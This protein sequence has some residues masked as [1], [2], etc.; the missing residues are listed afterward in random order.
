MRK[1]ITIILL[2]FVST[3]SLFA[4]STDAEITGLVSDKN[5][6]PLIGVSVVVKDRS[7]MGTVTDENGKF[8]IK[9]NA[10]NILIFNYVGFE[11][12]EIPV[13]EKTVINVTLNENSKSVLSEI[14][15]TGAGVQRKATVTGAITTVN[16]KS[17]NIPTA[18]ITNALAGNVA[19]IIAMQTSGEPGSNNS[20]F[21]IRGISTFGANQSALILVDGVERPFNEVNIEDIESFSVLK[22]ASATAI[23]GSKGANGV[24]I[25]TTKKGEAGKVN[26][27]GKAEYGYKTF[28]RLPEFVD[29]TTYATLANEAKITRNQ[30]PLYTPIE[31]DIFKNGLDSDLYPNISWQDVMLK[32]GSSSNRA[33]INMSGGGSTA[34]YFVSGSYQN[35]DGMYKSDQ[36]MKDYKTNSS[37]SRWNYRANVDMD[38]TKTTLVSI[39]VSGF[40]ESQNFPGLRNDIWYS[41]VGQTPVSIPFLYSNGKV[42]AY[43]TGNKTNPWVLATQTGYREYWK[44]VAQTNINLD[45]NLK[46]ITDGLKFRAMVAYDTR[47]ENNIDRKKWPEQYNIERRRD[48]DGN[49]VMKRVSTESIMYQESSASGYR[50][51]N[52]EAILTYDKLINQKHRMGALLKAFQNEN[53]TTSLNTGDIISGIA[54]RNLGTA[55]RVTYGY[56]DRYLAEFNFGYTGSENFKSGKQFGF[57]P[58]VSFGWNIAQEKFVSDAAPWLSQFKIRYSYGEVGNDKVGY[59]NVI[60]R[61]PYLSTISGSGIGGWNFGDI[62]NGN[63]Y[64][65]LHFEQVASDNLSWEVA[66][67]HNL[68]L[69]VSILNGLFSGSLDV[70]Q[71]TRDNIY[72][73]R[74]YLPVMV[75]LTSTPFANVGKMQSRGFDSQFNFHKKIEAFD[76]TLRGNITYAKNQ[77][78]EYD[79]EELSLPYMMTKGYRYNQAKGLVSE[80]L[81]KDYEEIR[82]SPKQTY[83]EYLPGDIKYKDV[84]GDGIINDDDRV[85]IGST[86]VPNLVYGLGMSLRWTNFDFNIH[87]QGSGKS[88]YFLNG[89]G[90]YPFSEGDWGNIL[91]AVSNPSNRWIS[92]TISGDPATENTSAMF[93]RLSYSS[94]KSPIDLE[95]TSGL[96]NNYRESTFWLRDGSYLRLKTLEMGYSVPQKISSKFNMN[97]VRFYLIGNNLFLW[98]KLKIWDPELGSG[99]GMKYPPMKMVTIGLTFNI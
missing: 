40:L 5:N 30:E 29:G 23:Y 28:T 10:Y 36:S 8:K 35:E 83:G 41:L 93:P 39:G 2:L 61:F 58:A 57:F 25:V 11:K 38:I 76:F 95:K 45:Q 86:R 15:I 81:F 42:P 67:K 20:E 51:Y 70:F 85:A 44:N 90:V 21:W 87:F 71:D 49:L 43:G 78:L 66:K 79:E 77:V 99:D 47:N 14:V 33:S 52:V 92:R 94:K 27:S 69:D 62:N 6:Q 91:T 9:A 98:D 13:K 89:P 54:N 4:Q 16:I 50:T 17:L 72:M 73:K 19:G 24:V 64:S 96:S 75:G 1:Y 74:S 7:G 31:L 12:Q 18:N 55:G 53:R 46:F 3:I 82:N 68:G 80:G 97:N 48:R 22:D 63:Y 32:K 84:N 65:G 88:S 56:D 60:T 26:I 37:M 34:R 59:N